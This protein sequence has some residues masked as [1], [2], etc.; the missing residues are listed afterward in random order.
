MPTALLD[1]R[2]G[3][4]HMCR[5]MGKLRHPRATESVS[6]KC[7][8]CLPR[9]LLFTRSD[10]L[11]VQSHYRGLH[12]GCL[13]LHGTLSLSLPIL[14]PG[15]LPILSHPNLSVPSPFN[16]PPS[17][18]MNSFSRLSLPI[19]SSILPLFC[20]SCCLT[21]KRKDFGWCRNVSCQQRRP[22]VT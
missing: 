7:R 3:Q 11:L 16:L 17:S 13:S 8:H 6:A 20:L 4:R 2:N 10:K 21:P 14:T 9:C 22:R 18:V 19:T 12:P 1:Q 15:Y 5:Q